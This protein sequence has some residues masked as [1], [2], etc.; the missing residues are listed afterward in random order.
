LRNFEKLSVSKRAAQKF[1]AQRFALRTRS[2]AEVKEKYQ[3]KISKRSAKEN[4]AKQSRYTPC[5]AWGER[6][7]R[8]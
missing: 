6:R 8:S 2:E 5:C 7:Y 3:V 1:G 4:K